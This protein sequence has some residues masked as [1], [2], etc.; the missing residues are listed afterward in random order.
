M[1]Q[2]GKLKYMQ[3]LLLIDVFHEVMK[4]PHVCSSLNLGT[5]FISFPSQISSPTVA[6]DEIETRGSSSY[7]F[8]HVSARSYIESGAAG[9]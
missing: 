9:T 1:L 3:N 4:I 2:K 7:V 8:P 6:T 5:Y